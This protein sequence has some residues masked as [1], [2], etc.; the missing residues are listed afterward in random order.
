MYLEDKIVG[1]RTPK[2]SHAEPEF[3]LTDYT[4][5]EDTP[6]EEREERLDSFPDIKNDDNDTEEENLAN[7]KPPRFENRFEQWNMTRDD[8][9]VSKD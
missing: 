8:P 4:K 9:R 6:S 3:H 1:L 7:N 5:R 2:E